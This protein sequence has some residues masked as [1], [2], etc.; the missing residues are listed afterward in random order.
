MTNLSIH[1]YFLSPYRQRVHQAL[2]SAAIRR[3][4]FAVV[5]DAHL[6]T[7]KSPLALNVDTQ[8]LRPAPVSWHDASKLFAEISRFPSNNLLDNWSVKAKRRK[9]TGT[10]RCRYLKVVRR[11]FR[12]GFR[13]GTQAKPRKAKA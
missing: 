8:L 13:E 5:A 11:R 4:L 2:E 12:N 10:G 7:F 6:T 1:E 9:T 3:I